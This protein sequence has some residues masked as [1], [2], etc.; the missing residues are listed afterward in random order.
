MTV[1]TVLLPTWETPRIFAA[2]APLR[3]PVAVPSVV[4]A[5]ITPRLVLI[6]PPTAT[7]CEAV[8]PAWGGVRKALWP[9]VSVVNTRNKTGNKTSTV[10][11]II[12][13]E[14]RMASLSF[15]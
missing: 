5:S 11:R 6:E 10:I 7:Q 3:S 12:F 9:P 1:N 13:P 2:N 15:A 4:F 8:V 14:F